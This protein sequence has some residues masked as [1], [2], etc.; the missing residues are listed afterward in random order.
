MTH[1]LAATRSMDTS[2][3]T[4]LLADDDSGTGEGWGRLLQLQ[5]FKLTECA[6]GAGALQDVRTRD[7]EVMILVLRVYVAALVRP[8]GAP[9]PP[10][11]RILT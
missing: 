11:P 4:V 1:L 8:I 2:T 7:T 5:G 10:P 9:R 3:H 6:S